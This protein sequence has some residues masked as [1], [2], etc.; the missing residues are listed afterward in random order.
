[1][2][3]RTGFVS[4]SSSSSFI[5]DTCKETF[6]GMDLSPSEVDHSTCVRGH[7]FCNESKIEIGF[8]QK[9]K[10]LTEHYI[11]NINSY[12]K[13]VEESSDKDV[14]KNLLNDAIHDQ[15]Q[16]KKMTGD[17]IEDNYEEI[18]YECSEE[19]CPI[20]QFEAY[21]DDD[22]C[23]Y[24]RL[25]S[26]ITRDEVFAIIK[27]ANKRRRKLYDREYIDHVCTTT[28]KSVGEYFKEL[29]T[30]FKSYS[31]FEAYLNG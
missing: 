30:K 14:Y 21:N 31:E 5:C 15:E 28:K 2:K 6:E 9:E 4:N 13:N 18:F 11:N 19:E 10:L 20:C 7:V 12:R 1:M 22:M 17:E 3:I 23:E 26:G 8:Q 27:E 24:L 29:K 16:F 25:S